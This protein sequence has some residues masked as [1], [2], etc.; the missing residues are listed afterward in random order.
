MKEWKKDA[1][2][3]YSLL[4][5]AGALVYVPVTLWLNGD[6]LRAYRGDN[7]TDVIDWS[8]GI[9][10]IVIVILML[11]IG[12]AGIL[13][14]K[15]LTTPL[16]ALV[17]RTADRLAHQ[18]RRRR[19]PVMFFLSALLISVFT[20]SLGGVCLVELL[21]AFRD[22]RPAKWQMVRV[23]RSGRAHPVGEPFNSPMILVTLAATSLLIIVVSVKGL[24]AGINKMAELSGFEEEHWYA[25]LSIRCSYF[26]APAA[27]VSTIVLLGPWQHY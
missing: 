7:Y 18:Y 23:E 15:I 24:R 22:R 6:Q 1:L 8:K 14:W 25:K 26:L 27:C 2:L 3:G 4:V 17:A 16:R 9:L 19:R 12:H 20:G 10:P 21:D 13:H 11:A 5:L